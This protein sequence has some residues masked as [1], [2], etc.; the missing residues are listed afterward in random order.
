MTETTK[1]RGSDKGDGGKGRTLRMCDAG[2]VGR[3]DV[4]VTGEGSGQA[5]GR[6]SGWSTWTVRALLVVLYAC[7]EPP[8][9]R[10]GRRV[11]HCSGCTVR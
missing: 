4:A 8:N 6:L 9:S 1:R 11:A 10:A 2:S 5:R 3:L 7:F